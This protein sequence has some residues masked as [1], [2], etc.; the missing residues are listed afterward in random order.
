MFDAARIFVD[1][2]RVLRN[3]ILAFESCPSTNDAA[4][5]LLT[6]E[7]SAAHGTVIFADHQTAGRGSRGRVW[8]SR[9]GLGILCSIALRASPAP[10]A[11][12]LVAGA[13][14]A[15]RA[16]IFDTLQI[17]ASIKWPN[18]ILID[19]KK[20]CGIL[21]E[22]RLNGAN[23]NIVVG[24]GININHDP[25]VDFE[26]DVRAV[27][28]SLAAQTG[29]VADHNIIDRYH[30]ANCMLSRLDVAFDRILRGDFVM[31]EKDFFEGLRGAGRNAIIENSA[32]QRVTGVVSA[33]SCTRGIEVISD[34]ARRWYAGETI[35]GLN[36]AAEL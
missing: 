20:V 16:A 5:E 26:E 7:G 23:A 8:R 3:R 33:F 13:A 29:R 14:A 35:T 11:P 12:A 27:A 2:P 24:I 19:N 9:P 31:I 4:F 15:V 18:D 34:G 28:T 36:E 17:R 25:A 22:A 30:F 6:N 10:P 21:A 32:G 1:S